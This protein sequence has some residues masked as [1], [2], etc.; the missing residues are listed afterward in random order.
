MEVQTFETTGFLS[1]MEHI[2]GLEN[3]LQFGA[4]FA[5]GGD[6]TINECINGMLMRE[7]RAVVPIGLVPL[8]SGNDFC[9][10]F[11]LFKPEDA[12]DAYAAGDL[13]EIDAVKILLDHE[14]VEAVKFAC[15]GD[16]AK[17]V[18][19]FRYMLLNSGLA[20]VANINANVS[21]KM[22]NTLG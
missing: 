22:L 18:S 4:I 11:E 10:G 13:L 20:L 6:G 21:R 7:D 1:S 19:H 17:E 9:R 2:K 14:S 8:G 15:E 12:V 5:A 3:I 16:L